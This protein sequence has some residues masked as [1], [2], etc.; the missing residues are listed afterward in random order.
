MRKKATQ[1]KPKTPR[2]PRRAFVLG[3]VQ[4]IVAAAIGG[5]MYQLGVKQND[6][7]R[8]LAEENRISIRLLSPSRGLIYDRGGDLLARNAHLY[9]VEM[10]SEQVRE[11]EKILGRLAQI[12]PLS[13]ARIA[14]IMTEIKKQQ[15]FIPVTIARDLRWEDIAAISANAP[16]LP[17][18]IPRLSFNREYPVRDAF[19]HTIGYVGAV[20][21]ADLDAD[22]TADPLLRIPDFKIGKVGIE[23]T[24]EDS[25]RGAAGSKQVEVNAS[26]RVIRELSRTEPRAGINAQITVG[27]RLQNYALRALGT[28]IGSAVVMDV[29]NGDILALASTPTFDPNIFLKPLSQKTWAGLNDPRARPLINKATSGIYPPGST[30]KMVVALA[31]LEDGLVSADEKIHCGGS[32]DISNRKFHCWKEGG[33]GAVNLRRALRESCDVFFYTMA[34]RLGIEKITAMANRLGLGITPDIALSSAKAGLTPTKAWKQRVKGEGWYLGDTAN[35]SIGQGFVLASPLQL[36][37]MTARIASGRAV[38]TR[39]INSAG[40]QIIAAPNPAP[41]AINPQHLALIREGMFDV[42]NHKRGTAYKSRIAQTGSE[43][44]GKTGTSQVRRI[45]AAERESG[46]IKNKDLEWNQRDHALFVGFAPY[47]APR[48]ALSVVIEHG[49]SG[50]AIA[51][52]IARDIMLRTLELGR[53]GYGAFPKDRKQQI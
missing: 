53:S 11:P 16:S 37:I 38:N 29:R 24:L 19:C 6:Q 22:I 25:L 49:G 21:E 44:A 4:A 42:T 8:L 43:M 40:G 47:D 45:R 3:G 51:A 31:A 48:F 10:I 39:L 34:T 46:V 13:A 35:S 1:D 14:E 27:R 50:S 5:R 28:H 20:S 52:P 36:A 7:Y 2:L 9:T 18:V 30:F 15:A 26:G 41:L 33:H 23:E 17:G 32:L 12:I